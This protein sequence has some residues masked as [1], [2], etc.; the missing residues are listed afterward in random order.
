MEGLDLMSSSVR[1]RD[2]S[3]LAALMKLCQGWQKPGS[4]VKGRCTLVSR[5]RLEVDVTYHAEVIGLFKQMPSKIYGE[6]GSGGGRV[7]HY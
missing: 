4:M 1:P 7:H 6:G 3:A 2:A 5:S